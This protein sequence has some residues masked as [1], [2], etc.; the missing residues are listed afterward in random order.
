M[1]DM[2]KKPMLRL[3]N[4]PILSKATKPGLI[5]PAKMIFTRQEVVDCLEDYQETLT[6]QT[7]WMV[8]TARPVNRMLRFVQIRLEPI[9]TSLVF[10]P[11]LPTSHWND[12]VI[13]LL[14]GFNEAVTMF[15][16]EAIAAKQRYQERG[17]NFDK[18]ITEMQNDVSRVSGMV[19]AAV[20]QAIESGDSGLLKALAAQIPHLM[21]VFESGLL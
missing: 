21:G 4:L 19:N 8:V 13:L 2:S 16:E 12:A 14:N 11:Y 9:L 3:P 1:S 15:D 5:M 18:P 7:E 20:K 17:I 6:L 10:V